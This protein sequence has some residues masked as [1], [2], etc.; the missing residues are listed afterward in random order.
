MPPCTPLAQLN[1]ATA[2]A[3]GLRLG[4]SR[5]EV[6]RLLGAPDKAR[7]ERLDFMSMAERPMTPEQREAFS[8]ATHGHLRDDR[9]TRLR[10]VSVE[11]AEGRVT[12]IRAYQVTAW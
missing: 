1:R 6:L 11:L 8:A 2:T 5:D 7:P 4:M 3:G 10:T 9:M 12:A